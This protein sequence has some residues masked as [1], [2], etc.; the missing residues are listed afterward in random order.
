MAS[1]HPGTRRHPRGKNL[2]G[3]PG[4][5]LVHRNTHSDHSV[6]LGDQAIFLNNTIKI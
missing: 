5:E 6:A 4:I 2:A 3:Y 1:L